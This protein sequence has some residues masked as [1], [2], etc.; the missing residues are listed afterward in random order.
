MQKRH[1]TIFIFILIISSSLAQ[2]L[3]KLSNK[4]SVLQNKTGFLLADIIL[5]NEGYVFKMT[6]Y[7]KNLIPV[8]SL[9]QPVKTERYTL[10]AFPDGYQIRILG[11][12]GGFL[13]VDSTLKKIVYEE[14]TKQSSS[15]KDWEDAYG[16]NV[17]PASV[18][19]YNSSEPYYSMEIDNM[20]IRLGMNENKKS[21]IFGFKR[22]EAPIFLPYS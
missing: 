4:P 10:K 21:I 7:D 6:Q 19:L 9:I 18:R 20:M 16:E 13:K 11:K 1:F 17:H 14:S 22:K 15:D 5:Q 8:D 2:H 3:E 12:K